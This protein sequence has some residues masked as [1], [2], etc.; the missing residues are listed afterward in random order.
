MVSTQ[1]HSFENSHAVSCVLGPEVHGTARAELGSRSPKSKH[2]CSICALTHCCQP[3]SCHRLCLLHSFL[4]FCFLSW[5]DLFPFDANDFQVETQIVDMARNVLVVQLHEKLAQSNDGG[6]CSDPNV[7]DVPTHG[8][9]KRFRCPLKSGWRTLQLS[10]TGQLPASF[11]VC[12]S[13]V[14]CSYLLS[15]GGLHSLASSSFLCTSNCSGNFSCFLGPATISPSCPAAP[16]PPRHCG[17]SKV[18]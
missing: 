11:L 12:T 16:L 7:P 4:V 10:E 13:S 2:I 15:F 6:P 1:T 3:S 17:S 9:I 14:A 5:R 8:T 18:P